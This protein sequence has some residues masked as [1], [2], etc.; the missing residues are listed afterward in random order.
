MIN[1][2]K[3][4]KQN[5]TA[6]RMRCVRTTSREVIHLSEKYYNKDKT[7]F[8]LGFRKHDTELFLSVYNIR[9]YEFFGAVH[10]YGGVGALYRENYDLCITKDLERLFE[11]REDVIKNFVDNSNPDEYVIHDETDLKFYTIS[12]FFDFNTP[13]KIDAFVEVLRGQ[14]HVVSILKVGVKEND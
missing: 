2:E 3:L 13:E 10:S 4:K 11:D 1:I 6:G 8:K 12:L 5:V 14:D 7:D 9:F